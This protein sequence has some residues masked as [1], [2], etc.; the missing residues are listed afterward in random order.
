MALVKHD[1][2]MAMINATKSCPD[3]GVPAMIALGKA[4][5]NYLVDNTDAVYS[6]SGA[7]PLS[8]PDPSTSFNAELSV[9]GVDFVSVPLNFKI[10]LADLAD[11]LNKIKI[12]PASGWSLGSLATESGTF[13]AEQ[14]L[15]LA[16]ETDCD[17]A[18]YDAFGIIAQGIIDGWESYF[19]KSASGTHAAYSGSASLVSVS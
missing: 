6:W 11:F 8:V 18:M 2:T 15:T 3:G 1:L 19:V 14:L 5:E 17:G 16:D 7:D 13:T 10:W 12:N 4:V 9:S